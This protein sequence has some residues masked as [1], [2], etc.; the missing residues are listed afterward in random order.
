MIYTSCLSF[1][2]VNMRICLKGFKIFPS[3]RT[4]LL[5]SLLWNN[6]TFLSCKDQLPSWPSIVLT[7][8]FEGDSQQQ[9][10]RLIQWFA[11]KTILNSPTCFHSAFSCQTALE[12]SFGP[13]VRFPLNH[14]KLSKL[15][16]LNNG[17]HKSYWKTHIPLIIPVFCDLHQHNKCIP[18]TPFIF[19]LTF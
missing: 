4:A 6:R 12:W 14:N 19:D 18:Y 3:V 10:N 15:L 7:K 9:I 8:M 11:E 16:H 17:T 13:H 1:E 2:L 5:S